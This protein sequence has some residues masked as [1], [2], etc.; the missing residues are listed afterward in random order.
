MLQE[1]QGNN[2]TALQ[3]VKQRFVRL[4]SATTYPRIRDLEYQIDQSDSE[5]LVDFSKKNGGH[6][7]SREQLLESLQWVYSETFKPCCQPIVR[8]KRG[9]LLNLWCAPEVK[10][11]NRKV[12]FQEVI[13]FLELLNRF[14]PVIEEHNYFLQWLA[15]VV[16]RPDQRILAT[17]VLRSESGVGKGFLVDT[18][19][20]GLL[21]KQ[22]VAIC[23]LD[24]ATGKFN[25]IIEGKTLLMIDE[26]NM[27]TPKTMQS[28]KA[29][30][31]NPLITLRRKNKPVVNIDNYINFII[32]SNFSDAIIPE[33]DDRRLWI[34][35]FIKHK[36]S[37]QETA[38]F[39][40]DKFKPWYLSQGAQLVRDYL[41]Q[42]E[43][44]NFRPSDPA[45]MTQSK[46]ELL[47]VNN[48]SSWEL[49]VKV[50]IDQ[51]LIVTQTLIREKLASENLTPS[52]KVVGE[53]L[54]KA[55]CE[56]RKINNGRSRVYV[57]PNGLKSGIS[58]TELS[59]RLLH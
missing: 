40:G 12:E 31:G 52:M 11:T 17:P 44:C 42:V 19:L 35:Q 48:E 26:V 36:V 27:V 13:P 55:G 30:L 5:I 57:T 25:D 56:Q 38:V 28:L 6:G 53:Y 29:L 33:K 20:V 43:L 14:F 18:L 10:P 37:Q 3:A 39:L 8:D 51:H 16:R 23:Q 32:A 58:P 15:H 54:K 50:M 4:P 59:T 41:E 34:P 7:L 22:S 1:T 9:D 2:S 47:N 46:R 45:P 49:V 21:N 24:E